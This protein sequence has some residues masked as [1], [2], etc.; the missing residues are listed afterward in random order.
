MIRKI[1]YNVMTRG[2][3]GIKGGKGWED[4]IGVVATTRY[5][6]TNDLTMSKA[7]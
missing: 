2:K 7:L 1:V 5:S 3:F 4:P 6:R